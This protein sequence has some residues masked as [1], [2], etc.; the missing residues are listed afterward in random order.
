LQKIQK[1]LIKIRWQP[2]CSLLSETA[3]SATLAF[4]G[5]GPYIVRL[6]Q[7]YRVCTEGIHPPSDLNFF[8]RIYMNISSHAEFFRGWMPKTAKN[9][10]TGH[11]SN[12][13]LALVLFIPVRPESFIGSKY[14][15]TYPQSVNNMYGDHYYFRC[16]SRRMP[17]IESGANGVL[18]KGKR[19][20]LRSI[21]Q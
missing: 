9:G 17:G 1:Q 13:W 20:K 16:R 8:W 14:I 5:T 3:I 11:P 4:I 19:P 15:I 18:C 21:C 10:L 2:T 6:I 7:V 12:P